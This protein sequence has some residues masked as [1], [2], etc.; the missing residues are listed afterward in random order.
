MSCR[1]ASGTQAFPFLVLQDG[2]E[3]SALLVFL[4][5]K[6][7][8]LFFSL[9]GLPGGSLGLIVSVWCVLPL[10]SSGNVRMGWSQGM[11]LEAVPSFRSDVLLLGCHC[12]F[13][14]LL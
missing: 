3:C 2:R 4:H 11:G 6:P 5:V 9:S 14:D 1:R 8:L 12:R 13:R 7:S 10:R